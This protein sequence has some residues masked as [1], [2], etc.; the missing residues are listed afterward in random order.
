MEVTTIKMDFGV[1]AFA[2]A[3]TPLARLSSPTASMQQAP[4]LAR[5]MAIELSGFSGALAV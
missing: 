2:P 3:S 4:S 5:V 1:C